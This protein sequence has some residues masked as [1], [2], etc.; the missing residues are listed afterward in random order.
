VLVRP[1]RDYPPDWLLEGWVEY[2]DLPGAI[3]R[4]EARL[5]IDARCDFVLTRDG[6]APGHSTPTPPSEILWRYGGT[7]SVPRAIDLR[8]RTR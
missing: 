6:L 2:V 5:W 3:E 7:D 4:S 1:S 8:A